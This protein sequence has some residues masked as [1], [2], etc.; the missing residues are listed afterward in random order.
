MASDQ[1]KAQCVLWYHETQSL[2][3]VQRNFRREYGRP[4]PNYVLS[5]GTQS[6]RSLEQ[7]FQRSTS[8]STHRASRELGNS[9][10]SVQKFLHNRLHLFVYKVQITQALSLKKCLA[11]N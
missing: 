1:E 3:T 8:K 5:V 10:S 4:P 2:I 7:A 11:K 9:Q 6:S